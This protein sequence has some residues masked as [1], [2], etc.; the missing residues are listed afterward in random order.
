[1]VWKHSILPYKISRELAKSEWVS[2]ACLLLELGKAAYKHC[3]R[4]IYIREILSIS[5]P[6]SNT[7]PAED[8][9]LPLSHAQL[10]KLVLNNTDIPIRIKN[11]VIF[12]HFELDRLLKV[13]NIDHQMIQDCIECNEIAHQLQPGASLQRS[14]ECFLAL[15]K[16]EGIAAKSKIED[17]QKKLDRISSYMELQNKA[18][19]ALLAV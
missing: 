19:E 6:S 18:W 8:Q 11:P 7:F 2:S 3:F 17:A 13:P 12:H 16:R 9:K 15:D 5:N 4:G 14:M 1:M 10:G